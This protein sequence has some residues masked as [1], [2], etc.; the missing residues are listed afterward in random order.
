MASMLQVNKFLAMAGDYLARD[1]FDR[2]GDMYL[3]AGRELIAIGVERTAQANRTA[4]RYAERRR[5]PSAALGISPTVRAIYSARYMPG[6]DT[7]GECAEAYQARIAPLVSAAAC[8][9]ERFDT[10]DIG[11]GGPND[12]ESPADTVRM[13]RGL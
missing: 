1:R 5:A 4:Q 10:S 8:A 11:L 9:E 3:A 7:G 13:R 6:Q 12:L 2:A